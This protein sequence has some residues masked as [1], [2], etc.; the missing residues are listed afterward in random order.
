[1]GKHTYSPIDL[2]R[3]SSLRNI[4]LVITF[5]TFCKTYL[6]LGP[7]AVIDK[8]GVTME[9]NQIAFGAAEVITGLVAFFYVNTVP[10]VLL[11]RICV[12]GNIVCFILI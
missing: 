9:V 6:I 3:Y 5:I 2:I 11:V 10:R 8:I 12:I 4:T 1:M 7:Y